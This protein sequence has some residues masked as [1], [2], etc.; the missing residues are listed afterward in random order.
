MLAA[1]ELR[2]TSHF[3][4]PRRWQGVTLP[5]FEQVVAQH[6]SVVLR[7]CRAVVGPADAD[8]AW[9][10]TFLA[11]LVAYPTLRPDSNIRG[12]LVTIAH[13]KAVDRLRAS[14]RAAVP[15]D[16]LPEVA[17]FDRRPPDPDDALWK[18]VSALP[19]KQRAAVAYHHIAGLPYAEVAELLAH[20][21]GRRPPPRRRRHR[22]PTRRARSG[23]RWL[24]PAQRRHRTGRQPAARRPPHRPACGQPTN[25]QPTRRQPTRRQ[26]SRRQPTRRQPTRR[27]PTRRQQDT[28]RRPRRTP[29]TGHQ[30]EEP[31][32]TI[33]DDDII[34]TLR[35]RGAGTTD[36]LHAELVRRAAAGDVLDVAYRTVDSPFGGLL[37]AATAKGVVRVAFA[38]EPHDAVLA[39]LAGRISPRILHAPGRLDAV[40][41]E[42]EE[43]FEG[44]RRSF[45]VPV[46]RQLTAGFRAAV[47]AQ[48]SRIPYGSTASYGDV[49]AAVG[50]PAASRAVGT[51]CA[52]NPVPVVVPCHR[53]VRADG[54]PG[55]YVGGPDAKRALLD[56]EAR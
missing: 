2:P 14:S 17:V 25:R 10:E 28:Q 45:T 31:T 18:A 55:G 11:A 13:R 7:V 27:Q 4:G 49:A 22:R 15:V 5:P 33:T 16:T 56:L 43:Y 23:G 39:A 54:T 35:G 32:V 20:H 52:N 29:S 41:A 53:V 47:L 26:P 34:Q 50:H 40:A 30:G 8:D 51:A 42:L 24:R 6:G 1:D 48:L 44:R 9:S 36:R 46:D 12:W 37:V 3:A 21:S 38:S 19:D